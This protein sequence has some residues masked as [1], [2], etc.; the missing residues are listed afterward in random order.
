MSTLNEEEEENDEIN[1]RTNLVAN[2]APAKQSKSKFC[3]G[4]FLL[5]VV[6]I[7][8]VASSEAS[9]YLFKDI[10][11]D[12][13]YMSTYIKTSM[14]SIYLM[15]FILYA[16]WRR[17]CIR[18]A[19][20]DYPGQ[21]QLVRETDTEDT[22]SEYQSKNSLSESIYVPT[23][24]P[25]ASELDSSD[26]EKK[27]KNRVKFNHVMEVRHL[28]DTEETKMARMNYGAA[29]RAKFRS[30]SKKGKLTVPQVM[31]ISFFFSVVFF[32]GNVA[33]Q[34]ALAVSEVSLVNVLSSTSG[35]FTL[36][37]AA[38]FPSGSS[39]RFT[40]SKL[41]AVLL[42]IAGIT[43]VGLGASNTDI[44]SLFNFNNSSLGILWSLIGTFCYALYLVSLKKSVGSDDNLDVPMFFGFVGMFSFTLLWPGMVALHYAGVEPFEL[45]NKTSIILVLVNGLVG[46][47]IS[48]LLWIWGCLLT[49]SLIATM[50]LSLTI[51][52]SITLDIVFRKIQ[53]SWL[54]YAGVGPVFAAF[55]C[56]TYLCHKPESDPILTLIK[57][58]CSCLCCCCRKKKV[59]QI[60][61]K[62]SLSHLW[63]PHDN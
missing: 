12:K 5:L 62:R 63:N 39:D 35:L 3:L 52:L 55:L 37:L 57:K 23:K 47:V 1:T 42:S 11:Y 4:L 31:R 27:S 17:Q 60:M 15:G 18:C 14:F 25:S 49:S 21:Y 26:G 19:C 48:E 16:P 58:L 40:L 38:L 59:M 50:S 34:E 22:D 41:C 44:Q 43:M 2:P 10:H 61:N 32:I 51:P 54:F 24:L 33:Y 13:P 46:T 56:V 8:W 36:I 7:I 9:R 30:K 29:L 28:E 53:F 6:D 45:P 20:D